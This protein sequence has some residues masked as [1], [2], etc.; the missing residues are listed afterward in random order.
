MPRVAASNGVKPFIRALNVIKVNVPV[1]PSDIEAEVKTGPYAAKYIS[2]LKAIGFQFTAVKDGR[3]I[4]SYT[5]VGEPA[6]A[7][8]LRGSTGK[9][10]TPK[11]SKPVKKN[12]SN[13]SGPAKK[14][15]DRAF[16]AKNDRDSFGNKSDGEV[17]GFAIDPDF[18]GVG[19][20][21][22]LR[23]LGLD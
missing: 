21:V 5:L 9:V 18:D 20:R 4:V 15:S 13:L 6:D 19:D 23:E 1:T 14:V 22:S 16:Q 17:G 12:T 10:A 11:V 8:K 7:E 3:Q 2:K